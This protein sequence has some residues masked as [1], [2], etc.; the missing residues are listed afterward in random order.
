[1]SAPTI[2]NQDSAGMPELNGLD[3]SLY[4]VLKAALPLIGWT[5]EFDDAANFRAAFKNAGTGRFLR[6]ID[7][8]SDHGATS[9]RAEIQFYGDMTDVNTG[10]DRFGA[11][12]SY[13]VKSPV[14]NDSPRRWWIVGNEK[15]FWLFAQN[16]WTSGEAWWFWYAGDGAPMV[17][18]DDGLF[19]ATGEGQT[20]TGNTTRVS[21]F[22]SPRLAGALYPIAAYKSFAGAV[23]QAMDLS[24]VEM[25]K[26]TITSVMGRWEE[27]Y[28]TTR[29]QVLT[30]PMFLQEDQSYRGMLLGGVAP[31]NHAL[32]QHRQG[33]IVK[34]LGTAF[35]QRDVFA[36]TQCSAT[37]GSITP[38]WVSF[39]IDLGDWDDYYGVDWV[40]LLHK[41]PVVSRA[42]RY[43]G[44]GVISSA[45][46][47]AGGVAR[48][49]GTPGQALVRLETHRGGL[50]DWTISAA[51]GSWAFQNVRKGPLYRVTVQDS[52]G[53]LAGAMIDHVTAA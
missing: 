6:I 41:V 19:I 35:G 37:I 31:M 15:A 36:A 20:G 26:D 7:K 24:S 40:S 14:A 27:E 13:W 48:Y 30:A 17:P 11:E 39:Y 46:V 47:G 1:M 4:A 12:P 3:G 34:G 42:P 43:L 22:D 18:S 9:I 25:Q 51:D 45:T 5:L 16:G 52:S 29:G 10:T 8:A 50:V 53:N 32:D 2:L 49:D 38:A 28:A 33:D 44:D 21:A 23:G